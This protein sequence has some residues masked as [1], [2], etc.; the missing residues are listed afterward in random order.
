VTGGTGFVF[1]GA[2]PSLTACNDERRVQ[3][4][5]RIPGDLVGANV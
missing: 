1:E 2:A 4:S 5:G 3:G